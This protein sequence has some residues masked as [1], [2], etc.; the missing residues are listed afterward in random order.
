MVKYLF[1]FS[2]FVILASC[3]PKTIVVLVPDEEDRV[4]LVTV[5][6]EK[7][8]ITLS[9]P[10]EYTRVTR[11]IGP[12]GI[13]DPQEQARMFSDVIVA[14]PQRPVSF[15]LYFET[16]SIMP[17]QSSLGSLPGIADTIQNR[18]MPLVRVVG[19]SD[20]K[21]DKT[22]NYDLSLR[23]AHKVRELLLEKGVDPEIISITAY[24]ENDPLVPTGPNVSEPRNRRVEILVR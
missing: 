4:G 7:D 9:E 19:H 14:M 10:Y 11:K 21:G 17:D 23:R 18:D 5:S 6:A 8:E 22:Y 1:I 16:Y 2:V 15:L 12:V 13:M 24:G 20:T 3:A